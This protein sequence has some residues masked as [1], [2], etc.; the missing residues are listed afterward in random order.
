MRKD[1]WEA[2]SNSRR[3]CKK[4]PPKHFP[5]HP[6]NTDLI[7]KGRCYLSLQASSR[8]QIGAVN[9]FTE[10]IYCIEFNIANLKTVSQKFTCGT[11]LGGAGVF[12]MKKYIFSTS[13]H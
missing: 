11:F 3:A 1:I 6:Y 9:L 8:K 4:S 12:L 5:D 10:R 2:S 7:K 13:V